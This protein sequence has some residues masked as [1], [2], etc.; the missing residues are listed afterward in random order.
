MKQEPVPVVLCGTPSIVYNS[1]ASPELITADTGVIVE[2]GDI[3]GVAKAVAD[4]LAKEKP[5]TACRE[6]AIRYFNKED[7]YKEYINLYS[8][9]KRDNNSN[10]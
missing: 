1:T 2:S 9:L 10:V 3:E 8:E 7:R 6:R 4:L 5:V